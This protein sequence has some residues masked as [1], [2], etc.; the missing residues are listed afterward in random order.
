ML[1]L[2]CQHYQHIYD[3]T[4]L[5]PLFVVV[6]AS[7]QLLYDVGTAFSGGK[8]SSDEL[9]V[10][11]NGLLLDSQPVLFTAAQPDKRMDTHRQRRH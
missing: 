9:A 7:A 2:F 8:P 5:D 3:V 4:D 10:S 11:V 6:L 1:R